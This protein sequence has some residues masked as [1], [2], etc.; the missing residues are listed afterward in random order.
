MLE[1]GEFG[2]LC[3]VDNINDFTKKIEMLLIN[4]TIINTEKTFKK[5][6]RDFSLDVHSTNILSIYNDIVK[7]T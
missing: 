6:K 7:Q 4:K 1:N 2:L 5:L 3:E